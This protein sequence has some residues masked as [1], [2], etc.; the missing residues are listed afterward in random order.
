M[1]YIMFMNLRNALRMLMSQGILPTCAAPVPNIRGHAIHLGPLFEGWEAIK[2]KN[3]LV[4]PLFVL[5]EEVHSPLTVLLELLCAEI[6]L[7]ISHFDWDRVA[8]RCIKALFHRLHSRHPAQ[9][10]RGR[11]SAP[12]AAITSHFQRIIERNF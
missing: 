4:L 10:G 6:F 5:Q 8:M 7:V 11:G 3:L 2:V 9:L 1:G 12:T